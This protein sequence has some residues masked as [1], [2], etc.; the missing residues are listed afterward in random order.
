MEQRIRKLEDQVK[1]LQQR[2]TQLFG[3][4]VRLGKPFV[5]IPPEPWTGGEIPESRSYV[6][7]DM[8]KTE[9][10]PSE[11]KHEN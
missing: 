1:T 8:T 9:K 4:M 11:H 2:V 6:V 5:F 3:E 7:N 10:S